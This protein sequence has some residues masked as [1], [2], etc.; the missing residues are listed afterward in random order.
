[1]QAVK[2]ARELE[3]H[4]EIHRFRHCMLLAGTPDWQKHTALEILQDKRATLISKQLWTPESEQHQVVLPSTVAHMLGTEVDHLLIDASDGYDA[5]IIGI[6]SGCVRAGGLLLIICP[7]L[8]THSLSGFD[9]FCESI[10]RDSHSCLRICEGE[11]IETL[12]LINS[13]SRETAPVFLDQENAVKTICRVVSGQRKRP[14]V[15]IADRGRGKSAALGIAAS[16][17]IQKGLKNILVTGRSR[18]SAA[19]VFEHCESDQLRW[20]AADQLLSEELPCGLLLIDEAASLPLDTLKLLLTKYP[21]IALATTVHGYEGTGQGFMLRFAPFLDTHT[22]GWRRVELSTP[23]RWNSGDPLEH[24]TNRILIQDAKLPD[25]NVSN[26]GSEE[27]EFE[28][29]SQSELVKNEFLLRE[30]YGLLTLAHY[31]TR[32]SDLSQLLNHPRMRIF[33]L[34]R[35]RSTI[36][37]A[38]IIAEGGLPENLSKQVFAGKRRP[39]GHALPELLASQLGQ[40]LAATLNYARIMR[41]VIHPSQQRRGLGSLLV[42]KVSDIFSSE[43]D[44]FGAQFSAAP[45]LVRF[46]RSL[47]FIPVRISR[48]KSVKTGGYSAV[49]L[50]SFTNSG[51]EAVGLAQRDFATNLPWQL[52]RT[53]HEMN[54]DT[55]V[56]LISTNS[57]F[58]TAPNQETLRQVIAYCK[59]QRTADTL[60]GALAQLALYG[61]FLGEF[62]HPILWIERILVGKDWSECR[63]C[64]GH[65]GW[66][67]GNQRLREDALQLLQ[68]QFSGQLSEFEKDLSVVSTQPT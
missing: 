12:A 46:W 63:D 25:I 7:D 28:E 35:D 38:L 39:E 64:E 32:P 43:T 10:L 68:K 20:I 11:S 58:Q 62:K 66:K 40:P 41:I 2:V 27:Y 1:M 26:S 13:P 47:G 42:S 19:K 4:G 16:K 24:L 56:S 48:G 6:A 52:S 65:D 36:G 17:L 14:A 37:I 55:V 15:L 31:Q 61:L 53:L 59:G 67:S 45:G 54:V 60:P 30:I 29:L 34:S 22:R 50:K 9:R 21:R 44:I 5:S 51:K 8:K 23:I 3:A 57:D 33:R 18:R 49:V